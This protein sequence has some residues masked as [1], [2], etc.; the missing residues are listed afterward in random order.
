MKHKVLLVDDDNESLLRSLGNS[1][2]GES[3][4]V[5]LA[6]DVEQA[7]EKSDAGETET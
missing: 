5:V 6:E 2:S 1:F 4:E 7:I 3:Y